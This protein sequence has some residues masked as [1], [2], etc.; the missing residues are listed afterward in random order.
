MRRLLCCAPAALALALAF[1]CPHPVAAQTL[2]LPRVVTLRNGLQLLLAPDSSAQAVDVAVWYPTGSA[3]EPAGRSGITHLFERM[4]FRGSAHVPDGD[5]LRRV[6]AEGGTA[7]ARTTADYTCR[8]QT[9][10]PAAL[11]LAFELEADRIAALALTAAN[12]AAEK[13]AIE[14]GQRAQQN[15]V[16]VA[17][18]QL[19]ATAWRDRPYRRPVTGLP[20]DLERITLADCQAWQRA[21]FG[22]ERATVSVVGRFDPDEAVRLARRW[23]EPIARTGPGREPAPAGSAP[24]PPAA[25]AVQRVDVPVAVLALGWRGQGGAAADALPLALLSRMVSGRPESPLDYTLVQ[26]K[27]EALFVQS[28]FDGRRDGALFYAVAVARPGADT[29]AI[30]RDAV[31]AIEQ[32]AESPPPADAVERARLEEETATLFAWQTARNRADALG[33]AAMTGG[34]PAGALA[35]L[36]RLRAL[37]AADLQEVARR[38]FTA[39]HRSVAWVMPAH[40]SGTSR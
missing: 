2:A 5:H 36:A 7:N 33:A 23:L 8:W 3:A 16:T 17:L 29:T 18:E 4:L 10:P 13:R 6:L 20:G 37:T 1:A 11:G 31:A 14:D 30:E 25:R 32:L 12:L 19:Y 39:A 15:P 22:P 34:D 26:R 21:R 24:A 40:A 38:T 35:R 27:Q 28:G 9:L